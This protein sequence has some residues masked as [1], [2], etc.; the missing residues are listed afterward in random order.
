MVGFHLQLLS[1]ESQGS[2]EKRDAKTYHKEK[3]EGIEI[4]STLL[5]SCLGKV[6]ELNWAQYYLGK[7]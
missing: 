5:L 6:L 3:Q 2:R 4:S 1:W 7:S